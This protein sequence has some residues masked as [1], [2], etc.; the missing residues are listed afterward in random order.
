MY[1]N[2]FVYH[3]KIYFYITFMYHFIFTYNIPDTSTFN[4]VLHSAV[5]IKFEQRMY[6]L[7]LSSN[8]LS[9]L[10]IAEFEMFMT[11]NA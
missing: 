2:H 8:F 10:F 4:I 3:T 7:I 5:F 1:I 6:M 9:N 11:L